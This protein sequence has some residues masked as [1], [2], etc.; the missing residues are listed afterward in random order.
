MMAARSSPISALDAV[1]D[2]QDARTHIGITDNSLM[3]RFGIK[4]PA[5]AD[6]LARHAIK[7]PVASNTWLPLPGAAFVARLGRQEFLVEGECAQSLEN[8]EGALPDEVYP[9]PRDDAAMILSGQRLPDLLRQT[10][11][12]NFAALDLDRKPVLLTSMVGVSVLVLPDMRGGLP[13]YRLWCDYSYGDYLWRT[14][15]AIIIE[16]GGGVLPASALTL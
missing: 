9:V 12:V 16:L 14:L 7:M 5:A 13:V 10:C 6:W 2:V 3:P 1:I 4:G 11:N 8:L 15:L